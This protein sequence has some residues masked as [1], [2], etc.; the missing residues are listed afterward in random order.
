MSKNARDHPWQLLLTGDGGLE[1]IDAATRRILE[2]I[3]ELFTEVRGLV[4]HIGTGRVTVTRDFPGDYAAQVDQLLSEI[5]KSN[6]AVTGIEFLGLKNPHTATSDDPYWSAAGKEYARIRAAVARGEMT[7]E[8][9][10]AAY[11]SLS[12][13]D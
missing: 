1:Q 5:F 8:Q 6:P 3:L 12:A 7:P 10:I 4:V 9:A 13:A 11:R 2:Q